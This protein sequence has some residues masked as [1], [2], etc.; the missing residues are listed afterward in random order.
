M[1]KGEA[2]KTAMTSFCKS[3]NAVEYVDKDI[4]R[5]FA[6]LARDRTFTES[7][8]HGL[9]ALIAELLS[10][11]GVKLYYDKISEFM[12]APKKPILEY[13][14]LQIITIGLT[15]F[16]IF[17]MNVTMSAKGLSYR[18]MGYTGAMLD[19]IDYV[20]DILKKPFNMD[21]M[22]PS[23]SDIRYIEMG[24]RRMLAYEVGKDV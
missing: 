20:M 3:P 16:S 15:Y 2:L 6:E 14:A 24:I 12:K 9:N 21:K 22:V 1:D 5:V 23:K 13:Y 8:K 11:D 7:E 4:L 19:R 17:N 10:V 18:K